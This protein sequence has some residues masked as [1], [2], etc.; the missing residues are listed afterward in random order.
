MSGRTGRVAGALVLVTAATGVIGVVPTP[1]AGAAV[2]RVEMAGMRFTPAR[3]QI[4]MGDT[5]IW[6]AD[7]DG[8]TVTARDG[9]FDSSSRGAMSEGD[10]FRW[11]F[12]VPG[13]FAYYCRVHQS[14]G[15]QGEVVVVDPS[16]ATTT[17][18]LTPVTA[19][20]TTSTTAATTET[21]LPVTTTSRELATS[22]TTSLRQ[23][24]STTVPAG[25]PAV[26]Q[27]PPALNPNAPVVTGS[28]S[29]VLPDAQAAARRTEAKDNL[30][31]AIAL[32]VIGGVLVAAG[33]GAALRAR[34]RRRRSP[35]G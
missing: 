10:Q 14:R 23:I 9:S 4:Q 2:E 12:R 17:T 1:P 8:H 18:R 20:A 29:S 7:D 31:P 11:R 22:S 28:G 35:S 13:T 19:A 21:T 15:M 6:E 24:T 26:P 32:G 16:A 27:E 34:G 5:V 25:T 30:G 3:V 33:G